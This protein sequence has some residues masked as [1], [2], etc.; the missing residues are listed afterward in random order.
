MASANSYNH[1][2]ITLQKNITRDDGWVIQQNAWQGP[3]RCQQDIWP[4]GCMVAGQIIQGPGHMLYQSLPWPAHSSTTSALLMEMWW[5]KRSFSQKSQVPLLQLTNNKAVRTQ[6]E[7][8]LTASCCIKWS[9]SHK[10]LDFLKEWKLLIFKLTTC[11]ST[12]E[13]VSWSSHFC[14]SLFELNC[15]RSFF[16]LL[17]TRCLLAY[18]YFR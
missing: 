1:N 16:S 5:K 7:I 4:H 2:F 3:E 14:N 17:F 10:G 9:R 11:C 18:V 6:K 8:T 12:K 13:K 15:I